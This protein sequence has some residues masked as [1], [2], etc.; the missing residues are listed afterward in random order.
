MTG[1]CIWV[2]TNCLSVLGFSPSITCKTGKWSR[3]HG[4]A[5]TPAAATAASAAMPQPAAPTPAAPPASAETDDVGAPLRTAGHS[6]QSAFRAAILALPAASRALLAI[7]VPPHRWRTPPPPQHR[8]PPNALAT[9][10]ATPPPRTGLAMLE[11]YR[12]FAGRE[13]QADRRG[14]WASP[15]WVKCGQEGDRGSRRAGCRGLALGGTSS[16]PMVSSNGCQTSAPSFPCRRFRAVRKSAGADE[17]RL[18]VRGELQ[19]CTRG[20][21]LFCTQPPAAAPPAVAALEAVGGSAA[22]PKVPELRSGPRTGL[23]WSPRRSA[24]NRETR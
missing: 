2:D 16:V 23:R 1:R 5:A 18:F 14:G 21:H 15:F 10:L 4:F 9:K 19:C 7:A 8:L 6:F 11:P 20:G 17:H 3:Y 24:S 13:V 12:W 22:A